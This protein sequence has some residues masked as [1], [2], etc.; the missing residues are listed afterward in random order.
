MLHMVQWSIHHCT[1][2]CKCQ[3]KRNSLTPCQGQH[4]SWEVKCYPYCVFWCLYLNQIS[5]AGLPTG[6]DHISTRL[7]A[8]NRS[9]I[10]LYGAL[11]VDPSLGSQAT[12]ALDTTRIKSYW[13]CYRHPWSCHPGS[14]LM[15]KA[16]SCEDEL[17]HHSHATQQKTPKS[18]TCFHNGNQQPSL[19]QSPCSSQVHQV[20]WWLDNRSSQINSQESVD[21]P[22][23]IH[24]LTPTWCPSHDTCPQEMPHCLVPK[25]QGTPQQDGMPGSNY[26]CRWAHRLG[27]LHYLCSEGKWWAMPVLGSPWPQWGHLPRSS[28]DA[29][30]G[31]SCSWVHA[32]SLLHQVGHPPWILVNHPWPGVQPAYNIQQSL[33]K[34]PFPVTSLWPC[35]FPRHLPEEV[36]PDPRRVPR[37]HQNCRWHHHPWL[38]WGITQYPHTKPHVD[39]PQIWFSV[40]H[41]KN[42]HEGSSHQFLWLP[43]WCWWCPPR[44]RKGSMP[45]MPYQCQQTSP[46]SKSS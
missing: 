7:T 23:Q 18:C 36:G 26:P 9:H 24:D 30:W 41:T 14:S 22:V 15:Q 43:L 5:P 33:W 10:P 31:G 40:W 13:A 20:H 1:A 35:L 39:C 46:N 8:Y 44:P 3:Q 37:M 21:S 27:I 42:T 6:L 32:L 25:G 38:H 11:N 2:A 34:I 45:Y 4:Q 16:S 17:C 28:Q 12:L 19:L 29:H